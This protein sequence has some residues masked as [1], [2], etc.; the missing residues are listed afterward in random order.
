M[1]IFAI[2]RSGDKSRETKCGFQKPD[3][4]RSER[5]FLENQA[6]TTFYSF[7]SASNFL[8]EI[9]A[10][11]LH[12]EQPFLEVIWNASHVRHPN[13]LK[14]FHKL[15]LSSCIWMDRGNFVT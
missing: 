5:A 9:V 4:D 1:I 11:A 3:M 10:V 12:E 15:S 7:V 2:L 6:S 14:D 13:I 8:L